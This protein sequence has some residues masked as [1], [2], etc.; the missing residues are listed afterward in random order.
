MQSKRQSV[1]ATKIA[2][3]DAEVTRKEKRQKRDRLLE[4]LA[5]KEDAALQE[6]TPDQIK[7]QLAA[8]DN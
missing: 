5:N 8:L 1:I 3:R 6:L 4:L 7:E 2:E